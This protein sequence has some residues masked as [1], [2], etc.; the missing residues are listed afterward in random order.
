MNYYKFFDTPLLK[1]LLIFAKLMVANGKFVL[2]CPD[3][4]SEERETYQKVVSAM[5]NF[6]GKVE[7]D[8]KD[9]K[10]KLSFIYFDTED[11]NK[12]VG[13][14]DQSQDSSQKASHQGLGIIAII[15]CNWFQMEKYSLKV[16]VSDTQDF[17]LQFVNNE[18]YMMVMK[19][20]YF[21]DYESA[22][23]MMLVGNDPAAVKQLGRKSKWFKDGVCIT[24]QYDLTKKGDKYDQSKKGGLDKY[25]E[26][27]D[28]EWK[29][30]RC[31]V[32]IAGLCLK[33]LNLAQFMP[34]DLF[35]TLYNNTLVEASADDKI[36]GIGM[37]DIDAFKASS[38]VAL[39]WLPIH[40]MENDKIGGLKN[41]GNLLGK[42]LWFC[43]LRIDFLVLL[44]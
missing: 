28:A 17:E 44:L 8:V 10:G 11:P 22:E 5:K 43:F 32:M 40:S 26:L 36:W 14:F 1:K 38:E 31:E 37:E 2:S 3:L 9:E 12:T 29:T 4:K 34:N 15:F 30:V 33:F 39:N 27:W 24:D 20:I 42:C 16:K 19:A 41:E 25:L 7:P 13:P 35:L 18:T 6:N 21:E 23:K